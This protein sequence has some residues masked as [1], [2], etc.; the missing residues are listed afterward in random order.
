M[1]LDRDERRIVE[2]AIRRHRLSWVRLPIVVAV[3]V[4]LGGFALAPGLDHRMG[5]R[6]A[7]TFLAASVLVSAGL[8]IHGVRVSR[9]RLRERERLRIE[10]ARKVIAGREASREP[11]QLSPA[12]AGDGKLSP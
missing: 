2:N 6:F 4:F 9:L 7:M 12:D 11:G 10:V 1:A 8:F 3:A 5:S